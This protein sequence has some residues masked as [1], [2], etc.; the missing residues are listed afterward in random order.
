MQIGHNYQSPHFGMA[1]KAS[2]CAK[3]ASEFSPECIKRAEDALKGTRTWHLSLMDNGQPRIY[4]NTAAAFVTEFKVPKTKDKEL[5]LYT[6]W[7]GSPCEKLVTKGQRYCE[8][9]DIPTKEA[10]ISA[11][12]KIT[13]APTLLDRVVE[14]IKVLEEFGTKY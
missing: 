6:R 14:I 4:N 10:A 7:D 12:T 3:K 9:V 11:Y 8:Y 5:K 2:E 13:K 1:F